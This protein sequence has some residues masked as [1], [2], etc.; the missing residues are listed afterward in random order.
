MSTG[1]CDVYRNLVVN[2]FLI[3]SLICLGIVLQIARNTKW[4][5]VCILQFRSMYE[6]MKNLCWVSEMEK[7][8]RHRKRKGE[9]QRERERK[10]E[11]SVTKVK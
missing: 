1:T 3:C 7:R 10:R 2:I 8:E 9:R 4:L 6:Y 5:Q 11:K